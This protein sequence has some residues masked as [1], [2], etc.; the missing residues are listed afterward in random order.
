MIK[1]VTLAPEL[2]GALPL[3]KALR[4][5]HIIVS[6]GHTN[7]TYA[8]MVAAI[9]AG[10]SQATHLFNAMR[11]LHQR[12]PGAVGALLLSHDVMAELI[13]DGLHLHPAIVEL[14]LRLKGKEKLLLVTD[15]MRAKCCDDGEYDLGGQTVMVRAGKAK[16][17]DGTLAG[18]TLRMPQALKNMV[19]FTSCSLADAVSMAATNPAHV[20]GL[21]DRKGTI[22]VGKDADLVVLN[23]ALDVAFTMREGREVF[24]VV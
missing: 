2:P 14:A 4:D 22:A 17:S 11:G 6:A 21:S 23:A 13:V 3:I 10:C 18:S 8:E 16:L 15:A 12:E 5:R 7:A 20:L 1:L 19:Q 24:G 9:R